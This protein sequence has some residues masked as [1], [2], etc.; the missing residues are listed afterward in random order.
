MLDVV[1]AGGWVVGL[2]RV[3]ADADGGTSDGRPGLNP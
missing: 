2:D 1:R 3:V